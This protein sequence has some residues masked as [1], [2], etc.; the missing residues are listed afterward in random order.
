MWLLCSCC[1]GISGWRPPQS[2]CRMKAQQRT[3]ML[4]KRTR[5]KRWVWESELTTFTYSWRRAYVVSLFIIRINV[6]D[7]LWDSIWVQNKKRASTFFFYLLTE[8]HPWFGLCSY[9][10]LKT[11]FSVSEQLRILAAEAARKPTGKVVGIIKRSWRPFCGM[12]N[13]AQIKEVRLDCYMSYMSVCHIINISTWIYESPCMNILHTVYFLSSYPQRWLSLFSPFSFSQPAIFS[14]QQTAVSPAFALKRVRL[15]HWQA[16]GSW[17]PSMAGPNTPD[18]QMW[19]GTSSECHIFESWHVIICTNMP[20]LSNWKDHFPLFFQGHFVRSLGSAG[21][22]DTEQEVLLLEHDVP[23]QAFSQA[24]LSF[25]PKMPW[26]ITP[27]VI[28]AFLETH[29]AVL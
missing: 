18:T 12:L 20:S 13:V 19:V 29:W 3:I 10:I 26:A 15:P 28:A 21:E 22:K 16:R 9:S 7:V 25:L 27:E 5:R 14:P 6:Q 2:C 8:W 1:R 17:L 23:H 11:S 24:V 4:K